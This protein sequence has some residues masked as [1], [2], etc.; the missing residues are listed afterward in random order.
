MS[1]VFDSIFPF[2]ANRNDNQKISR[3]DPGNIL[4]AID[5]PDAISIDILK[6]LYSDAIH[7]KDKLEDKAK[8]NVAGITIAISLILGASNFLKVISEKYNC[9]IFS[10]I[11]FILFVVAVLYLLIAG[12]LAIKV[13]IHENVVFVVDLKSFAADIAVLRQDYGKRISQ[14]RNQ[15]LIRNNSIYTSYE[16]IRNALICLFILLVF[17]AIPYSVA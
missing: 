4:D 17:S 10:W 15:N 16:C 12:I 6:G 1:K 8:I 5:N 13:L 3:K 9:S 2:I 11:V 7:Q 14:N